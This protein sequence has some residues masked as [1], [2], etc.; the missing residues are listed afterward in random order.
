MLLVVLCESNINSNYSFIIS[1]Y[2]IKNVK[3]IM[4]LVLLDV[5]KVQY[6]E[7]CWDL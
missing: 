6:G 5:S 1:R 7:K 3:I 2:V 4:S